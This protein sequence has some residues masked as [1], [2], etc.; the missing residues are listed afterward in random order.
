M[1]LMQ[2]LMDFNPI[3]MLRVRFDEMVRKKKNFRQRIISGSTLLESKLISNTTVINRCAN[4]FND[5][6]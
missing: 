5:E 1:D 2:C 6:Y 4:N 3:P